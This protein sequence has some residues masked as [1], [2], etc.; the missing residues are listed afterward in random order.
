MG[1]HLWTWVFFCVMVWG[2]YGFTFQGVM[3]GFKMNFKIFFFGQRLTYYK[4]MLRFILMSGIIEGLLSRFS[5]ITRR[6]GLKTFAKVPLN[7]R[8]IAY[9]EM[10]FL[11][12]VLVMFF[13][14][15]I[16]LWSSIHSGTLRSIA[17]RHYAFEVLNN[18]TEYV[19]H[20]DTKD[21]NSSVS[22]Y[23]KEG[24]RVFA[25]VKYE[26]SRTPGEYTPPR[27][28]LNLFPKD[29]RDID[30]VP[31]TKN[32]TK[33]GCEKVEPVIEFRIAYGI[34]L[35]YTCGGSNRPAIEQSCRSEE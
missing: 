35:D 14:L 1:F 16:G 3:L 13:G 15:T 32:K 7:D 8:G 20:R 29:E 26:E 6:A 17:A 9:V 30:G 18:R 10:I 24:Y 4:A 11:I 5:S 19:Y 12:P 27:N 22:Y 28:W 25:N 31:I 34:C 2:V 33:N 23:K 21:D